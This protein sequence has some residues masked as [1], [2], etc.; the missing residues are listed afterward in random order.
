MF[1]MSYRHPYVRSA[2]KSEALPCEPTFVFPGSTSFVAALH[3]TF[4]CEMHGYIDSLFRAIP[5]KRCY[6]YLRGGIQRV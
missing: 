6:R 2:L 4:I 5:R 1:P 3:K